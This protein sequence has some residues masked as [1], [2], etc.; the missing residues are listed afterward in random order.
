MFVLLI[1]DFEISAIS[2]LD[3]NLATNSLRFA[4]DPNIKWI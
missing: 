3:P 4:T 2:V 1:Y